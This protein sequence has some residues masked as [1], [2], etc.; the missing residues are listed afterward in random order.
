[1]GLLSSTASSRCGQ[2]ILAP[3]PTGRHAVFDDAASVLFLG[4]QL[5]GQRTGADAAGLGLDHQRDFFAM[6]PVESDVVG[7]GECA[8]I[9]KGE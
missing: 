2:E 6:A 7:E 1:M 5:Q 8:S 4:L 9:K 3:A